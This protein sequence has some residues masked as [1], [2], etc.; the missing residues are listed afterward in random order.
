MTDSCKNSKSGHDF[1]GKINKTRGNLQ[2]Q[3]WDSQY[4]HNH[5]ITPKTHPKE[6]LQENYCRNPDDEAGGPWCYTMSKEKRWDYCDVPMC[7]G[8]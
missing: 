8:W 3:R 4:P 7:P 2:C 1:R 5:Y 6:G